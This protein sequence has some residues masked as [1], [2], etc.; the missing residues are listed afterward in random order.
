MMNGRF[1]PTS[2]GLGRYV[3]ATRTDFVAARKCVN[4]KDA[5]TAAPI[6]SAAQAWL[7]KLNKPAPAGVK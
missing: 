1:S 2:T 3:N 5:G 6:A 4:S 7:Q